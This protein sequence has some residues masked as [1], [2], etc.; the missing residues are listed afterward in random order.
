MRELT[1]IELQAVSGG[2][3]A[4]PPRPRRPLVALL[5]AVLVRLLRGGGSPAPQK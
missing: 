3:I 4:P 2:L 5:V 1:N